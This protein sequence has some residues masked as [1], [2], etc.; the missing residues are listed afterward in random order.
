MRENIKIIGLILALIIAGVSL[1]TSIMSFT[2]KPTTPITEI[3]NYY[4]NTTI[5]EQYNVTIIE[6]YNTTIIEQYNTTIIEQFNT[7][8]VEQYNTT[9]VYNNTIYEFTN[10]TLEFYHFTN[11]ADEAYFLNLSYDITKDSLFLITATYLM[12]TNHPKI[13]IFKDSIG[14]L[15]IVDITLVSLFYIAES[16]FYELEFYNYVPPPNSNCSICISIWT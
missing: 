9:I 8:I 15:G 1:P 3:N 6:Q 11:I 4:Y 14:I 2:N 10:Q 13:T 16:G 5:I 7:T 12:N